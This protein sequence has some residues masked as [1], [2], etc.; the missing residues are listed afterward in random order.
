MGFGRRLGEQA[1]LGAF[2]D[3]TQEWTED[4]ILAELGNTG[5][6]NRKGGKQLFPS[7]LND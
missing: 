2:G 3:F 4:S 5:N 6:N 7:T 1:L